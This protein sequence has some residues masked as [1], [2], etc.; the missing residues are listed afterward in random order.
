M[1]H[2]K[3]TE[4]VTCDR[5]GDQHTLE[6]LPAEWISITAAFI[7]NIHSPEVASD[8]CETCAIEIGRFLN[9]DFVPPIPD[10][11]EQPYEG[12]TGADFFDPFGTGNAPWECNLMHDGH[13]WQWGKKTM[14]DGSGLM[15]RYCTRCSLLW[16]ASHRIEG[17]K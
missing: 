13:I 5:C 8:L 11:I 14:R 6:R 17:T 3:T 4:Y 15:T 9:G 12:L 10:R 2:S 16:S 7:A 1:R